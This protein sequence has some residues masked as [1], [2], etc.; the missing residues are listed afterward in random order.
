MPADGTLMLGVN[1]QNLSDNSGFFTVAISEQ[2]FGN[3]DYRDSRTFDP[4]LAGGEVRVEANQAWT[5][6]GI[7]VRA[8]DLVAF[9]AS[10]RINFGQGATATAGPNGNNNAER[11]SATPVRGMPVGG[12]IGRVGNSGA[13][14]IGAN[15]QPIRMPAD[16][17]LML[18]VNDQNL[19]DNSG[20]FTVAITER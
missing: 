9:R 18:G 17:T 15:T 10:G 16:G 1:D 13:F 7:T 11:S 14:P 6:T 12:L 3:G 19:E 5:N 2:S 4:R 20:F 8:G